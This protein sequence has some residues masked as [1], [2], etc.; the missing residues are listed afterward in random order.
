MYSGL[1]EGAREIVL[2]L[3]EFARYEVKFGM[4]APKLIMLE[5]EM[6]TCVCA[7]TYVVVCWF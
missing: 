1:R 4:N 7:S 5:E 2:C 3:M 6:R